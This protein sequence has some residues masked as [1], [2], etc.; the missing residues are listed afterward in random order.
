MKTEERGQLEQTKVELYRWE[1]SR[2]E[3]CRRPGFL[4]IFLKR[5]LLL[6][7]LTQPL[8]F[9][10]T[11]KSLCRLI[12]F[13]RSIGH[14]ELSN[15]SLWIASLLA[16]WR[17][18]PIHLLRM[19]RTHYMNRGM[20]EFEAQGTPDVSFYF[21]S[22][23]ERLSVV[24]QSGLFW[25]LQMTLSY[26]NTMS[27]PWIFSL[28]VFWEISAEWNYIYQRFSTWTAQT[29]QRIEVDGLFKNI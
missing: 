6:V 13:Q 22:S 17:T 29:C 5:Y 23:K 12:Y 11:S 24:N 18:I 27:S 16:G 19:G 26:I 28:Q 25:G 10:C 2:K 14:L 15:M 21:L 4:Y 9:I 1:K 8:S 3:R 7:L 20:R